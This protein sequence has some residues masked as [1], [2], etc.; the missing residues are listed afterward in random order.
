LRVRQR[1]RCDFR[2]VAL[3]LGHDQQRRGFFA[4]RDKLVRR[5]KARCDEQKKKAV[6]RAQAKGRGHARGRDGGAGG[7]RKR[8]ADQRSASH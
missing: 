7:E 6:R 1:A 4:R 8:N 5:R 2:C 3:S